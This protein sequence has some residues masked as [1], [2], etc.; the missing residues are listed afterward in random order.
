MGG[1]ESIDEGIVAGQTI[2]NEDID[3]AA[4]INPLKIEKQSIYIDCLINGAILSGASVAVTIDN[5][6]YI[7]LPNANSGT[8]ILTTRM[9]RGEITPGEKMKV[10]ILWTSATTGSQVRFVIQLKPA[11]AGVSNL[12]S[13][14]ERAVVSAG[15]SSANFGIEAIA[16]FPASIFSNEQIV[17]LYI[18]RDP[19]NVLDTLAADIKVA[20]II[21]EIN[22]R[23]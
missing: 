21:L 11:I 16:E 2:A 13:A 8:I 12:G 17:G 5:F 10:R 19:T 7:L 18:S 3:S 22:G 14:I 23:C 4:E 1:F 9:P 6:P 15:P 20:A